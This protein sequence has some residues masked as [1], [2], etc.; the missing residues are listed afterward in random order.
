MI[1]AEL[2]YKYLR[3]S[4]HLVQV[5]LL[6]VEIYIKSFIYLIEKFNVLAKETQIQSH[7]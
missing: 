6:I 2:D 4:V 3:L 7:V 5:E 1:L